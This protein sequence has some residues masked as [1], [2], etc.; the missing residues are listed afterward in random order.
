MSTIQ[1]S[2]GC[3]FEVTQGTVPT[4]EY[5]YRNRAGDVFDITGD[6]IKLAVKRDIGDTD[7]KILFDLAAVLTTPASGLFTLAYTGFHTGL[8]GTYPAEL[9]RWDTAT[10][11]RLPTDA[12]QCTFI[13]NEA[14]VRTEA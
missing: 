6:T 1:I 8:A 13:C 4:I 7:V 5:E 10:T 11:N 2:P 3:T 14:V 9:R 12:Y